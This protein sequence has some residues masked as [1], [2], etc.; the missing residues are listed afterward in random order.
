MMTAT[1]AVEEDDDLLFGLV[2][3]D[4]ADNTRPA[5]TETVVAEMKTHDDDIALAMKLQ[6]EEYDVARR[7]TKKAKKTLMPN[8]ETGDA[9]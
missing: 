5:A 2:G 9:S 6:E 3:F 8:A 7:E 1:P 4:Q